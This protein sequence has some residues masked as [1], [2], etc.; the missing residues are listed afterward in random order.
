[1]SERKTHNAYSLYP[2]DW[3]FGMS[4]G[5]SIIIIITNTFWNFYFWHVFFGR[6]II[7]NAA[8]FSKMY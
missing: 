1:M 5:F 6:F 7:K 2:Q 8:L 4:G 3:T